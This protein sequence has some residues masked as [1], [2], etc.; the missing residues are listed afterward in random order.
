M[1]EDLEYWLE[2]DDDADVDNNLMV[3]STLFFSLS[4]E[5]IQLW[6]QYRKKTTDFR[7]DDWR[8]MGALPNVKAYTDHPRA[9]MFKAPEVDPDSP[10]RKFKDGG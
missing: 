9:I 1:D 7:P 5:H 2:D 8:I 4:C 6:G 10:T 3:G